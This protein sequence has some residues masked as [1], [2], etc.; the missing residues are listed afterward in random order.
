[1]PRYRCILFDLD[2]TLS[3]PRE[4]IF[5]CF[6]L[7]LHSVGL[8]EPDDERL[9]AVIGP[10]LYQSYTE[11]YGLSHEQAEKAI[12]AYRE[13]YAVLGYRQNRLYDGVIPM[14][15]ALREADFFIALA[16]SKPEGP[17]IDILRHFGIELFF[18][19]VAAASMDHSRSEKGKVIAYALEHAPGISREQMLMVGDRRYDLLGARTHGLDGAGVLYGYGSR[20]ELESCNPVFLAQSPRELTDFVLDS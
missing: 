6:R 19:F 13:D 11:M 9:R 1:M 20:E 3:D 8:D 7:G 12:A 10:P 15:K 14:L 18:D 16:T 4:G 2:G 17:T 5:R